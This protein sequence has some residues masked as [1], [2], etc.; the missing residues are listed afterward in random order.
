M[1]KNKTTKAESSIE[2]NP[3]PRTERGKR[4]AKRKKECAKAGTVYQA[5]DYKDTEAWR[6]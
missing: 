5:K 2:H 3:A 4:R 1:A 6:K